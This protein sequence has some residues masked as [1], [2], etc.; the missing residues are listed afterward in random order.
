MYKL[1]QLKRPMDIVIATGKSFVEYFARKTFEY[2]GLDY[3]KYIETSDLYTRPSEVD[4]LK[5]DA[6]KAKKVLGWK[7]KVN[8]DQLIKIMLNHDLNLIKKNN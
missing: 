3:K 2:L 6:T 5:G 7:P 4:F 1:M 8:L